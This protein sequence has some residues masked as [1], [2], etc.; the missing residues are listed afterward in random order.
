MK[1]LGD[2]LSKYIDFYFALALVAIF[3][4]A[5]SLYLQFRDAD[6]EFATLNGSLYPL[7]RSHG[8]EERETVNL[9]EELDKLEKTLEALNLE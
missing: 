1:N 6:I 2:M 3:G 5:G 4:I 9:N 7:V 8:A